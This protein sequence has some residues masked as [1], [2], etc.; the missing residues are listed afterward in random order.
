M[1]IYIYIY[2]NINI[3]IYIYIYLNMY[4]HIYIYNTVGGL[5]AAIYMYSTHNPEAATAGAWWECWS[6]ER[7]E[8]RTRYSTLNPK[9]QIIDPEP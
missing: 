9:P 8:A 5:V 4:I 7:G 1:Y 2:I 6:P 3:Y